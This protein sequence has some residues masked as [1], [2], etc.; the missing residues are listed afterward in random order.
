MRFPN[1]N[2]RDLRVKTQFEALY[3]TGR[4][5]GMGTLIDRYGWSD[6]FNIVSLI[7]L[8]AGLLSLSLW[9][10]EPV[11]TPAPATSIPQCDSPASSTP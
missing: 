8:A 9:K 4:E 1:E 3:S 11:R 2:K 5:D 7:A 10:F 6:A